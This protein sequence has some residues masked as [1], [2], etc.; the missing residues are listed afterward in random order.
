MLDRGEL[1][2]SEVLIRLAAIAPRHPPL[3]ASPFSA[4]QDKSAGTE[5][6]A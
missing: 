4:P 6:G 5:A 2:L 3:V 1:S